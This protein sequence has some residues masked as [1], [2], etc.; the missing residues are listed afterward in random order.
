MARNFRML[1]ERMDPAQ[2][3]DNSRLVR[4][5]LQ[6]MALDELRGARKLTQVDMA[7][8]LDLPQ[9]SISRLEQRADMYVSTLRNYI[10]AMGGVLQIRAIFPDSG[11]VSISR[12]GEYEDQPYV[13]SIEVEKDGTYRLH[14]RPVDQGNPLETKALKP[15]ALVRTLKALHV[16][17][18]QIAGVKKSLE[19]GAD[20]DQA[21]RK[22]VFGAPELVAAGFGNCRD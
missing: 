17:D 3:A 13:L 16:G 6:R 9:S 14:A 1:Q 18:A 7:E 21:L 22:R 2:R 10:Q 5:G 19:S 15:S 20:A 11:V 8:M 4:E 12:F